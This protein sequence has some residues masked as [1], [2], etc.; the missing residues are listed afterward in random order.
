[1]FV[2]NFSKIF[3]GFVGVVKNC[4]FGYWNKWVILP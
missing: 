4:L 2:N 3:V 1:M